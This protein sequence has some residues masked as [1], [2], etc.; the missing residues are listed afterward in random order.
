MTTTI[1]SKAGWGE[2]EQA[3]IERKRVILSNLFSRI[4]VSGGYEV[5]V[6]VNMSY[7]QF[8]DLAQNEM[9][10]ENMTANAG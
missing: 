10:E 5:N 4:E 2:Y 8:M 6:T 7:R 9:T 3:S 1:N